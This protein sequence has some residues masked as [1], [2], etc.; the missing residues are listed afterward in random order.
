VV[1][2]GNSEWG[3]IPGEQQGTHGAVSWIKKGG[4]AQ[5][6]NMLGMHGVLIISER[7]RDMLKSCCQMGIHQDVALTRFM[8][9]FNVYAL[10]EPIVY[11]D[12]RVGGTQTAVTFDRIPQY[13]GNIEFRTVDFIE[14]GTSDFNT[15][16]EK[17]HDK[18]GLS[19]EPIKH[20]LDSLPDFESVTKVNAAI[21][22]YDGFINV[23]SVSPEIITK[24]NLPEWL[25]GCNSVNSYH[26]TTLRYVLEQKLD[27]REVFTVDRVPVM[28]FFT[29]LKKYNI[30]G[31][32][33]LKIDTEGHDIIILNSYL[34][35]VAQGC[36]W[37]PLIQKIQFEANCLTD[38]NAIES[39]LQRLSS[40]GYEVTHR[41]CDD[42]IVELRFP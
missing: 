1:Y 30:H 27:E 26:P 36:G 18:S 5:V 19:V 41:D 23:Y 9:D 3:M 2:L 42:I 17:A 10:Y 7:W 28:T 38:N 15:E 24:Y 32:R 11:Q 13:K 31:C 37:F 29:L 14:I 39:V 25:R 22:N 16:I 21:S 40:L 12:P 4:C 6:Y 20:Y 34:D 33:Y 8:K 35:C